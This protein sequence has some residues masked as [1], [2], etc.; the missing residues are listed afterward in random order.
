MLTAAVVLLAIA[1]TLGSA[2]AVMALGS[3]RAR[4][5]P[6]RLAALHGLIGLA[7]LACLVLV[8][9]GPAPPSAHGTASFGLVSA[10]LFALAALVGGAILTLRLRARGVG[11][12]IAIHATLAVSAFVI[13]AAFAFVR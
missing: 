5:A 8:L 3:E 1:V 13:F 12:L 11:P 2:L 7:G 10:W 4:A 9:R 6:W